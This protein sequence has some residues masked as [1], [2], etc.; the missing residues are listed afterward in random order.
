[1]P[2]VYLDLKGILW[3]KQ[4]KGGILW[5]KQLKGGILWSKFDCG[6]SVPRPKCFFGEYLDLTVVY[7]DLNSFVMNRMLFMERGES[8][9]NCGI[10]RSK[11]LN[12]D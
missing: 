10:P 7:L 2:T 6:S 5:S 12:Y 4:F 11:F 3:S 1:M 9:S 8:W